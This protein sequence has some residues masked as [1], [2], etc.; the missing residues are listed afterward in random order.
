MAAG[1]CQGLLL[2]PPHCSCFCRLST[3]EMF[4]GCWHTGG[5]M[6]VIMCRG[7]CTKSGWRTN[8][9]ICCVYV[10]GATWRTAGEERRRTLLAWKRKKNDGIVLRRWS[11]VVVY[12]YI[13]VSH[14]SHFALFSFFRDPSNDMWAI[15]S[16]TKAY[17]F[18]AWFPFLY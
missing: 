16:Y 11:D 15:L 12:R 4:E 7:A 2:L 17:S 5:V 6:I 8:T 14:A 3:G 13:L 9:V 1:W 18:V 10:L